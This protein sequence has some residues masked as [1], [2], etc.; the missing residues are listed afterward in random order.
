MSALSASGF[1][2]LMGAKFLPAWVR[3]TARA[4]ASSRVL[5]LSEGQ[6]SDLRDTLLAR[7]DTHGF[8]RSYALNAEGKL[9]DGLAE[10]LWR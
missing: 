8:D 10:K 2:Y 7:L 6:M 1:Q 4:S 5:E 9:L 3:M